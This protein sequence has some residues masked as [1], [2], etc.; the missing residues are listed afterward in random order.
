MATCNWSSSIKCLLI[1]LGFTYLLIYDTVFLGCNHVLIAQNLFKLDD[2]LALLKHSERNPMIYQ[3]KLITA[4]NTPVKMKFFLEQYPTT[5][6][7]ELIPGNSELYQ[8][9]TPLTIFDRLL[10]MDVHYYK[11]LA[12][13]PIKFQPD[14]T[15]TYLTNQTA[16]ILY[17]FQKLILDKAKVNLLIRQIS[18]FFSFSSK[19]FNCSRWCFLSKS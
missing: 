11:T 3:R 10:K 15:S 18:Y 1:D 13:F 9:R 16:N 14:F 6:L 5:D 12:P 7:N 2:Y 4:M 19:D 8:Q 17:L